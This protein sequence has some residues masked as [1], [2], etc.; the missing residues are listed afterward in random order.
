MVSTRTWQALCTQLARLR[1]CARADRRSFAT[2]HRQ[3]LRRITL[4]LDPD[5]RGGIG[6]C[7]QIVPGQLNFGSA[8]ILLEPVKLRGAWDGND[9]RPLC[10]Q[11]GERDLSRR[12][13]LLVSDP[14][15]E[16]DA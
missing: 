11:P 10:E 3:L 13:A 14:L 5:L 7:L 16:P 8:D 1:L 2:D 4:A 6:D 12:R 9:I 15:L